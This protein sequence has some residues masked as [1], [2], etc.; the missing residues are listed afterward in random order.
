MSPGGVS[1]T[2]GAGIRRDSKYLSE[3][4]FGIR[5]T[6]LLTTI[7]RRSF[8]PR[9]ACLLEPSSALLKSMVCGYSQNALI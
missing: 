4:V 2:R 5:S 9:E 8:F 6:H 1:V 7:P 3:K